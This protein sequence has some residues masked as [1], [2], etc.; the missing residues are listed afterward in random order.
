MTY[1][2]AKFTTWDECPRCS[3]RLGGQD[4]EPLRR[5]LPERVPTARVVEGATLDA[6]PINA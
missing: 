6:R 2:A 1:T 5:D 4:P 3:S